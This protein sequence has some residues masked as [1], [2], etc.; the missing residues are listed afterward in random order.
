MSSQSKSYPGRVLAMLPALIAV[1]CSFAIPAAAQDEHATK[2]E[3][4]GG[5]SFA[6]PGATPSVSSNGVQNGIV[7]AIENH[8]GYG[9]LRAYDATNVSFEL[10]DSN[11]A[12]NGR[13]HFGYRKFVPPMIVNGKVYVVTNYNVVV[14]GLL[15]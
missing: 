9:V 3:L 11:Q 14:F 8:N 12:A 5:Y 7:W 6:Y 4:Y 2:W 1:M 10:Y 13:D 15:H